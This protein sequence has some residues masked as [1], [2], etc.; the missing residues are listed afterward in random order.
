MIIPCMNC[1]SAGE[2]GGN[3]A[4]VDDGSVRVRWPGAPGWTTIGAAGSDCC[5]ET[6]SKHAS[7]PAATI[8]LRHRKAPK[9]SEDSCASLWH[10]QFDGIV[11]VVFSLISILRDQLETSVRKSRAVSAAPKRQ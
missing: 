7:V 11:V 3:V 6:D 1:T 8:P 9:F 5:A 10:L 2:C 4:R